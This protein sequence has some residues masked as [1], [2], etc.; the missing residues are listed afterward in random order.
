MKRITISEVAGEVESSR[1]PAEIC[2]MAE[3][4]FDEGES[5]LIVQLDCS[6]RS[7]SLTQPEEPFRED[8]LPGR[9]IL[10]E[11]VSLEDVCALT[12]E[13]FQ[14]WIHKVRQSAGHVAVAR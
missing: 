14:S 12:R 13:I 5:R 6:L 10:R 8:W 4:S 2:A 9:E 11:T 7:V 3:A 1:G